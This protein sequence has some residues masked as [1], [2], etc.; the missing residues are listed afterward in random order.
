MWCLVALNSWGFQVWTSSNAMCVSNFTI[1]CIAREAESMV[2]RGIPQVKYERAKL[3]KRQGKDTLGELFQTCKQSKGEFVHAVQ[4]SPTV[5]AVLRQIQP[6]TINPAEDL[7]LD[8]VGFLHQGSN[9]GTQAEY[10]N[11]SIN[12]VYK[13][14]LM[15]CTCNL[16]EMPVQNMGMYCTCNW[17][18]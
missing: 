11:M 12:Y 1:L 3:R 8:K 15:Y 13:Q 7:A 17:L 9:C 4:I 16:W 18:S 14:I 5:I 10:E 2:P 6:V